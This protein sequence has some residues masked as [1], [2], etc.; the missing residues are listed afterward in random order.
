MNVEQLS[1]TIENL[2]DSYAVYFYDEFE[3]KTKQKA[4]DFCRKFG[5][6][7]NDI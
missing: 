4:I 1:V 6:Q 5:L 2:G 7:I 3:F